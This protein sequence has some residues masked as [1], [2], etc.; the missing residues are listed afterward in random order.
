M[1]KGTGKRGHIVGHDVSWARKLI[2]PCCANWKTFVAHTKC[3]WT[4]SETFFV[5]RTQNL[6]PQQMLRARANGET[7]V[8]ETMCPQ[9]CVLVS[10][11]FK[12]QDK[13][14]KKTCYVQN[15]MFGQPV[16]DYGPVR[17]YADTTPEIVGNTALFLRLVLPSTIIRHENNDWLTQR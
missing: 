2:F 3:F 15:S 8:S 12:L 5:S 11:A 9:Q 16:L 17:H 1:F 14:K 7:F 6:C 13:A 4:K 10:R